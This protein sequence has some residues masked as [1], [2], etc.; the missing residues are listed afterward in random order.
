MTLT[1]NATTVTTSATSIVA[2]ASTRILFQMYNNG[3]DNVY[4][5][6]STSVT[7]SNG[8]KFRPGEVY[9]EK[10]YTGALYAICTSG[11]VNVRWFQVA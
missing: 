5:G 8:L 7:T 3:S 4:V 2:S 9:Q 11:T 10:T 1:A 6:T